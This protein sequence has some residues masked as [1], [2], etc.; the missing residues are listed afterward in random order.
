M[1]IILTEMKADM[2]MMT[3]KNSF[4]IV[5]FRDLIFNVAKATGG[6]RG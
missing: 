1:L 2:M 6:L 4:Q 5:S 3:M